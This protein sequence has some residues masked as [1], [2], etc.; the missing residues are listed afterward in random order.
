MGQFS[1][2]IRFFHLPVSQ[3]ILENFEG[4]NNTQIKTL[5]FTHTIKKLKRLGMRVH[6]LQTESL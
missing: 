4:G 2:G 5:K 6:I 1:A 3:Q